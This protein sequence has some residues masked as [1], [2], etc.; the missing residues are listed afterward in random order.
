MADIYVPGLRAAVEE[1]RDSGRGESPAPLRTELAALR[2]QVVAVTAERDVALAQLAPLTRD[3]DAL[4]AA[5]RAAGWRDADATGE[6]L[7]AW[8][9]RGALDDQ[10]M[11]EILDSIRRNLARGQYSTADAAAASLVAEVH[12]LRA[13]HTAALQAAREEGATKRTPQ[14]ARAKGRAGR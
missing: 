9:R 7:V 5:A 4:R 3:V 11:Q 8:V 12:R 1:A 2:R 6:H 13:E 14:R 10:E